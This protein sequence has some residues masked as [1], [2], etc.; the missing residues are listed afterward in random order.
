[1]SKEFIDALVDGN[2]IEAE[3]AFSITM[4]A[5]VGDALEVKRKEL[6]NTFVKS[7]YTDQE[8]DVNETD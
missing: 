8:S 3:K 4:A 2:N 5:R 6:A 1:M 7:S